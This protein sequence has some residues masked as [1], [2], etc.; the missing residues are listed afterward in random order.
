MQ[1]AGEKTDTRPPLNQMMFNLVSE[2][3]WSSLLLGTRRLLDKAPINGP[4][5]VYSIRSVVRDVKES[6]SWLT[7]RIDVEKVLGAQ[8][9]LDRLQEQHDRLVATA[10]GPVW[11]SRE[12]RKSEAAHRYFDVLSGVSASER[13]SSDL[14][15]DTA[16]EKIETRLAKNALGHEGGLA[17]EAEGNEDKARQRSQLELDQ[18]DEELHGE[19]EEGQQYQR[20]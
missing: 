16:F 15:S 17:E 13:N 2:G 4:K 10:D 1:L 8:Y 7:R 9:D 11:G 14:I 18:R 3:Y 19:N 6:Q 12:L 5:G 20:P